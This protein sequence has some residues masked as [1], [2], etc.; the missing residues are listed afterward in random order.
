MS[1]QE[2]SLMSETTL[3]PTARPV[4]KWAGGK[5]QLLPEIFSRLPKQF[6]RYHEPF[7]GSGAVF[8]ALGPRQASLADTNRHLIR[9]YQDIQMHPEALAQEIQLLEAEFNSAPSESKKVIYLD[10]RTEFNAS[11]EESVRQS[12][13]MVFLNK[14]GFNGMYRENSKGKFNIPFSGRENVNLPTIDHIASCEQVL[15]GTEILHSE[16]ETVLDR[17]ATND[18]VYFDPPYV[19]VSDT[20]SFTAYQAGGFNQ[21]HQERLAEVVKELDRQGV[22]VLLSNSDTP[23]ARA[24]Y[25]GLRIDQV[26]AR[27]SINSKASGRGAVAELLVRNY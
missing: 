22:F 25:E 4:L 9:L 3:L 20:S 15:K 24:L 11:K 6:Q 23:A 10:K 17:V 2:R 27:R 1:D 5:T 16:F 18:L 14:T 12:A 8:F 7:A 19:P 21:T 13:L 26:F